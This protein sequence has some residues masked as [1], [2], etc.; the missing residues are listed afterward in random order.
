MVEI[1]DHKLSTRQILELGFSK[2]LIFISTIFSFTSDNFPLHLLNILIKKKEQNH[3]V[4]TTQT[5]PQNGWSSCRTEGGLAGG[6]QVCC[7]AGCFAQTH[8][9]LLGRPCDLSE[10][11]FLICESVRLYKLFHPVFAALTL[12][13]CSH[14]NQCGKNFK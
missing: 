8:C 3:T 10:P 7:V 9:R 11:V 4:Q 14:G 13:V 12:H 2:G 1:A 5:K 6:P